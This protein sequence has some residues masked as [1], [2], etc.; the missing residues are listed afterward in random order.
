ML[1]SCITAILTGYNIDYKYFAGIRDPIEIITKY[2]IRGYSMIL[3][4]TEKQHM[5][6]YYGHIDKWGGL[7]KINIK[8]KES[9]KSLFGIRKINDE[10]FKINKYTNGYPDDAY[11]NLDLD[12]IITTNDISKW[13]NEKFPLLSSKETGIDLISFKTINKDGNINP[14]KLW[15]FDAINNHLF[16][17]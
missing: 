2:R 5:A 6:Y 11:N 1:P 16:T 9:L 10:I 7:F 15:L 3:N 4:P 14:I 8:N 13:Y 12:Y 17:K